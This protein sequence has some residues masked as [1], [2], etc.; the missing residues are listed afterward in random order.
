MP[1]CGRFSAVLATLFSA[2]MVCADINIAAA[3]NFAP[4]LPALAAAFTTASGIDV[5]FSTAST[6]SLYG[7]INNGAPFAVMLS[8][9]RTTAEN[10]ASSERGIRTSLIDVS[11]GALVL[12]SKSE[13]IDNAPAWLADHPHAKIAL[14][15]PQTAPYGQ[16]ASET[17]AQLQWNGTRIQAE[18]IAQAYQFAATGNVQAAFIANSHYIAG[19]LTG[20]WLVPANYH[21]PLVHS[22]VITRNVSEKQQQQAQQ[23]LDFLQTDTA[24]QLLINAGYRRC[25]SH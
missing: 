3:A 22:A 13:I 12:W 9:D 7:Q 2:N 15:N 11:C 1:Y 10:I 5:T 18:N 6:G 21:Q 8:A 14:A 17:L 4:M 19:K 25:E 16:A 20:G 23:F 24:Q